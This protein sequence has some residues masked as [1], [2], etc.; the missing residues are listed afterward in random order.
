MM[1]LMA[2]YGDQAL[3]TAAR[4]VITAT[5]P[6]GY[7]LQVPVNAVINVAAGPQTLKSLMSAFYAL[8]PIKPKIDDAVFVGFFGSMTSAAELLAARYVTQG[9]VPFSSYIA[10]ALLTSLASDDYIATEIE[11]LAPDTVR[12]AGYLFLFK[13]N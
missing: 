10:G 7:W 6:K 13:P 12:F 9:A 4:N 11:L 2:T 1:D 3:V 5:S 8:A